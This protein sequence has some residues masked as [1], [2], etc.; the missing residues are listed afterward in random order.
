MF[1]RM[2]SA[3]K[4]YVDTIAG[5]HATRSRRF[6]PSAPLSS[7]INIRRILGSEFVDNSPIQG[8]SWPHDHPIVCGSAAP[9][10]QARQSRPSMMGLL[11]KGRS[12]SPRA[13]ALAPS[14]LPE[15]PESP[16]LPFGLF[17]DGCPSV[18]HIPGR[19]RGSSVRGPPN[20]SKSIR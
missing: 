16:N 14:N 20:R 17:I 4:A 13:I 19:S 3:G 5:A 6:A 2:F 12:L 18:N 7:V 9:A 8:G 11:L 10:H 1:T 15:S